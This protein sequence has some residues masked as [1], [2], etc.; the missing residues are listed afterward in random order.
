MYMHIKQT[1]HLPIWL[2]HVDG[3]VF[4]LQFLLLQIFMG[5]IITQIMLI[6]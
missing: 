3:N 1:K 4:K 5:L 6:M 2:L